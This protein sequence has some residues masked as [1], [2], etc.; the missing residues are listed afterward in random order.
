MVASALGI[1]AS[2]RGLHLENLR[3][4]EGSLQYHFANGVFFLRTFGREED[5]QQ[6]QRLQAAP[7]RRI[8]V[9]ANDQCSWSLKETGD[10]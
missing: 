6:P 4:K 3:Q 1:A 8:L 9:T 7:P 2:K 5:P 10:A